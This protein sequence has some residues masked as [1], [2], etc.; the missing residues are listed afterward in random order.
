V[1]GSKRSAISCFYREEFKRHIE[2]LQAVGIL[3]ESTDDCVHKACDRLIHDIDCL[4]AS[5]Q[6]PLLA[7]TL[8]RNFDTLSQ[9][10]RLGDRRGH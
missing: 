6:F 1:E 8:L 7:E 4:A 5:E 2:H 9:L 3:N 10:S